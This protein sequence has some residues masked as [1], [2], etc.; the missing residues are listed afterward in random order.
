[1]NCVRRAVA[2]S[3]SR[4]PCGE[5]N[6]FRAGQ[7]SGEKPPVPQGIAI[8][9]PGLSRR[10]LTH[11]NKSLRIS[12]TQCFEIKMQARQGSPKITECRSDTAAPLLDGKLAD[13]GAGTTSCN[14]HSCASVL[15]SRD[16]R[17]RR[18]LKGD[19]S[20]FLSEPP[21]VRDVGLRQ[22]GNRRFPRPRSICRDRWLSRH[23]VL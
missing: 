18:C 10:R 13:G 12:P 11:L 3:R 2:Q 16:R 1:M 17:L 5:S 4:S 8:R 21:Q 22:L 6:G 15:R 9:S 23:S 19:T 14:C 7:A 20:A